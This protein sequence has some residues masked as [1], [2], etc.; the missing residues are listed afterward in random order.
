MESPSPLRGLVRRG[1]KGTQEV[2]LEKKMRTRAGSAPLWMGRV[3]RQGRACPCAALASRRE[4]IVRTSS[5]CLFTAATVLFG[6]A[7][8]SRRAR[9]AAT[10]KEDDLEE[11]NK[12][13]AEAMKLSDGEFDPADEAWSKIIEFS[14][15][16][17]ASWSNR[18]TFRLQ[19]GKFREASTDLARSVE[20]EGGP[21]KADG[22]LLN[23]WGNALGACG[24][25]DGALVAY[26]QA[27]AAG[28]AAA[29]SDMTEIAEANHALGLLQCSSDE[30]SL[31]EIRGLLRKD[32]SFLD[33]KA[34]E[35]AALWATG[36]KGAAEEAWNSLQNSDKDSGLY[37]KRFAIAR[38]QGRWPPR[39]TAALSAFITVQNKGNAVD[40]DG[41]VKTYEFK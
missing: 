24:D 4:A 27:A 41:T 26:K 35:V 2:V 32:P 16:T 18:G 21:E 7:G 10:Y 31:A 11:L 8:S 40:Y 34:A 36:N 19:R 5:L 30:E 6:G 13:F 25:W 38:V 39:P 29:D 22:Y 15:D 28:E 33:M 12:L 17:S 23:N 9:A 1:A 20:L 37:S 3:P 14:P